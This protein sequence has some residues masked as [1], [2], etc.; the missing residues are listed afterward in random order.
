MTTCTYTFDPTNHDET[1]VSDH[2]SCP[3]EPHGSHDHCLFHLPPSEYDDLDITPADVTS[4]LISLLKTG[5]KREKEFIGAELTHLDLEYLEIENV[6]QHPIDLR[7]TT[8][9]EGITATHCRIEEKLQL[10]HATLGAVDFDNTT[11]EVGINCVGAVFTDPVDLF[12]VTTIGGDADFTSATF[13]D[14]FSA[15]VADFNEDVSFA[16]AAFCDTV[17][18]N[19]TQFYGR[20]NLIGDNTT[21][22]GAVFESEA[23]FF[24]AYF[25]DVSF[26]NA[27]FK[28]DAV[29]EESIGNGAMDFS[30]VT[31]EAGTNFD[32]SAF[33][34]EIEFTNTTFADEASFIGTEFAG[35]TSLSD[36][37]VTFENAQ[38]ASG[39]SFEHAVFQYANFSHTEFAGDTIF[40]R[41]VFNEDCRFESV[42]F[43]SVADFD[44]VQFNGDSDFSGTIFHGEAIFRGAEFHGGTN[45]LADDAIF[46]GVTFVDDANFRDTHF[47][48]ADFLDTSFEGSIDFTDAVFTDSLHLKASSFGS[49]TYFTFTG[50]E[51][52]DGEII[53]PE[54]GWVRIDMTNA[55]L[56]TVR[57]RATDPTDERQLLDYFRF[58]DTTFDEFDFSAHT[59]YLD[60]N[61][62]NLHTFDSGDE[63]HEF[64][65]EMT[66][67]VIE[68]TYLK[69]KN[70]A[71]SQSN[72]KAAGEFRVKRQQ[73]ARKK[74]A[75]ITRDRTE[76]LGTRAQN[77]LRAV[78]NLF[79]GL[80]CGYG[81]RLYRI[82]GVFIFFPILTGV[83]FTFGGDLF[84]TQVG[85][86]SLGQ[87]STAGGRETLGLNLYYSYITYLTVGYGNIAPVGAGA[88]VLA[89]MLVYMNV[90]LAGL[91]LYAL[92]KRSEV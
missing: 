62:W 65:V 82:T 51:I 38:F 2:W 31:F 54:D 86:T 26:E 92:I 70:N 74:F 28:G 53:Q 7:H 10:C 91:F 4:E 88:R 45:Y 50:A 80:T 69:A 1:T 11:F 41:T 58:C 77:G 35:G 33:E 5:E 87:L 67:E 64:A 90:I 34:A 56:G 72:I 6:D 25:K 17:S 29:F 12:E 22:A 9:T 18:F 13:E 57:L 61:D 55:T 71:S 84:A 49:Q 52:A 43:R 76:T 16:D 27:T 40:E 85:Q 42:V 23:E 73:Y 36:D 63:S 89:P 20:S 37:D 47:T 79:L 66:P 83:L 21:F 19:G 59:S 75:G 68:K 8:I 44:E 60:R 48:S 24:H 81:L 15:D 78:E 14:T 39:V 46:T 30:G 3:H 32:D